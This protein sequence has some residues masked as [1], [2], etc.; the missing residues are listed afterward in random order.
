MLGVRTPVIRGLV[1]QEILR[2]PAGY[3]NRLSKLVSAADTRRFAERYVPATLVGKRLNL[4]GQLLARYSRESGMP[5][6]AV[7]IPEA[8]RGPAPFLSREIAANITARA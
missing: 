7:P 3:R 8:G 2:A 5:L 1:A 6:L 4:S